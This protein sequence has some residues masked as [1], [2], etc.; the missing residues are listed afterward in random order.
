MVWAEWEEEVAW[1]A[2]FLNE[3]CPAGTARILIGF[4]ALHHSGRLSVCRASEEIHEVIL[5]GRRT[6]S[7]EGGICEGKK[8]WRRKVVA[9]GER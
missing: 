8:E 3:A 4:C 7:N 6:I 1:D 9:E 5:F 2:H